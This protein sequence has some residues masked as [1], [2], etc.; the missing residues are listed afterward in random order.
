[1]KKLIR[2]TTAVVLIASMGALM[3]GCFGSFALTSKLHRWNG[4]V[5]NSKFVNELV[6]LGLCILPVYEIACLGDV[7]IF[8]SIEFWGGN[9]PIA[10][11]AGDVEEMDVLHEGQMYKMIKKQNSLTL[12]SAEGNDAVNFQYFPKEKA[13]YL[14][15]GENKVKVV[16]MKDKSVFTYLPNHKTLVFDQTTVDLIPSE[17]MAAK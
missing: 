1:M 15:E 13:W 9:N 12:A 14:M 4:E 8:N 16:E 3:S 6:F 2:Q 17:V 11:N 10:M 5:S 7:L